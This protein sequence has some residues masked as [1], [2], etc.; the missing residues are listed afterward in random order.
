[1]AVTPPGFLHAALPH[2]ARGVHSNAL[3][4]CLLVQVK[5][6]RRLPLDSKSLPPKIEQYHLFSVLGG[7]AAFVE[8]H[9]DHVLGPLGIGSMLM[10]SSP[11]VLA[12][13]FLVAAAGAFLVEEA[14][15]TIVWFSS[16]PLSLSSSLLPS[17]LLLVS[18]LLLLVVSLLLVSSVIKR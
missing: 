1:M 18:L 10:T 13:A 8:H 12:P 15:F 7:Y 16:S 11:I 3:G 6:F 2:V 17:L 9:I 5:A 14:I 4:G